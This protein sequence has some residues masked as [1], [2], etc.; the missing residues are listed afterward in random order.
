VQKLAELCIQRPVFAT[1]LV[2]AL[3]VAGIFSY[4]SLGVGL[5][6]NIAF[7]VVTVTTL[8]P[9]ASPQAIESEVTDRIEAAVNTVAGVDLITSTSAEGASIVVVQFDLDL[10]PNVAAQGVRDK[11]GQIT[12]LPLSAQNPVIELIDTGS[13]PIL[14]IAVSGDRPISEVSDIAE[15]TIKRRIQHIAGVGQVLVIGGSEREIK[16]LLDPQRMR[17]Y[18]LTVD[19]LISALIAANVEVPGGQLVEGPQE[20]AVRTIGRLEGAAQVRKVA[21]AVRGDYTVQVQDVAEVV[22]GFADQRT[23]SRLNGDPAVTVQ[24]IKQSGGNTVAIANDVKAAL[25]ELETS[26]GT[27]IRIEVVGDQ[28]VFIQAAVDAIKEH[29]ILGGLLAAAIVFLFLRNARMTLIAAIAIPTSLISTFTFMSVAGYTLNQITMLALTLMIGIVIDDAIVVMENIFRFVDE[30]GMDPRTASIEATREIG[31]AVMATTLSLLAVFLPV[32]FMGGIVGRFMSSFGLTAAFAIVV[33]LIVSFTLTPMMAS[34]LIRPGDGMGG[35]GT[36]RKSPVYRRVENG[37]LKSLEWSLAHRGTIVVISVIVV[38]LTVP[39][40]MV[41]PKNFTPEDDESEFQITF[42]TAVGSSLPSTLTV[43]ERIASDVRAVP[44]VSATLST[45]GSGMVPQVNQGSMLVK[46]VPINERA[47]SQQQIMQTT[48]D[49]LAKVPAALSTSVEAFQVMNTGGARN[50]AIQFVV[51][52]PDLDKLAE[53]ADQLLK[54][55]ET[56]P[57]VVD[58]DTTAGDPAPELRVIIDR[59]RA[60]DLGVSVDEV[61]RAV[62]T[63]IAGIQVGTIPTASEQVPIRLQAAPEFRASTADIM[64]IPVLSARLGAVDLAAV[65]TIEEGTEPSM[66]GRLNLERQV[67]VMA[68]LG[69]GGSQSAVVSALNRFV[70]TEMTLD[71]GYGAAPSAASAELQKAANA[72]L[73]A[74]ALSLIFMYMVLAAQFESFAEPFVILLKLPL[75]VPMGLLSLLVAQQSLNMFSALGLILLFGIVKKNAI[76]QIDHTNYL[77][78]EKGMERHAAI[79]QANKDRLRPILMT[80]LA[81]VAGMLPLTLSSGVGAGTN[82]SIGSLVIGGQTLCLLLTLVAVPVFTTLFDDLGNSGFW[83]GLGRKLRAGLGKG[84]GLLSAANPWSRPPETGQSGA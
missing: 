6:P 67:T 7:P 60:A 31:F 10:D 39:I 29:M 82:R 38:L 13:A 41:L 27:D 72:F 40:A 63:M 59:S 18:E 32:A 84:R 11:V 66:I 74:I 56:L 55:L 22:D 33:S 47:A 64:Q 65:A 62:N 81:L 15:N 8:N 25:A 5:Y 36:T 51:T 79:M 54:E 26:L 30:K 19:E 77:M 23:A 3:V 34:R 42:S 28:S 24:V 44:G 71:P 16:V 73:A 43:A 78:R 57:Y 35:G 69:P 14:Q 53:Y 68:D 21:V 70:R 49:I 2:S 76:L 4:F 20:I 52:G 45:V 9:G 80:T 37:Y 48:R 46:L 61:S 12:E 83:G 17:S 1:M 75:V 58:P 50:A